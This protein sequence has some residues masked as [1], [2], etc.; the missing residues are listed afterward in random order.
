M[1]GHEVKQLQLAASA[2]VPLD[3]RRRALKCDAG[4]DAVCL[5]LHLSPDD[6]IDG[7]H[8]LSHGLT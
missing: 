2:D 6:L 1:K 7:L 4:T 5:R 8:P 3:G